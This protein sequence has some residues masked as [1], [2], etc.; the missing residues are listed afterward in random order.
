LERLSHDVTALKLLVE[1]LY[2]IHFAR[3]PEGKTKFAKFAADIKKQSAAM[4][5]PDLPA[6][7]SDHAAQGWTEAI[8]ELLDR[9][10]ERLSDPEWLPKP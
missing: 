10:E 8:T 6:V 1:I 5:F 4:L 2:C 7:V 9:I 3:L